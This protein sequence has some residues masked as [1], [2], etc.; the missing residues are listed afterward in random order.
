MILESSFKKLG[1]EGTLMRQVTLRLCPV[2]SGCRRLDCRRKAGKLFH[3]G[4]D[5]N[6]ISFTVANIHVQISKSNIDLVA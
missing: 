6:F 2:P 3:P 5:T 1:V 4:E